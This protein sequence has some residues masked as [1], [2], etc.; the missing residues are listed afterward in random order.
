[1]S[2]K[3]DEAKELLDFLNKVTGKNFRPVEANMKLI[4]ARLREYEIAELKAMVANQA[5]QWKYDG[6]R[7]QY[8]RPATLFNATKCAQ[9]VGVLENEN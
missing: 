7:S 3:P 5:T 1:M 8:L 2:G 9:Y 4:K 6:D